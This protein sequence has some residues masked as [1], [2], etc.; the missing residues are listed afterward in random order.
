MRRQSAKE[1]LSSVAQSCPTFCDPADCSMPGLLVHHQLPEIAQTHVHRVSDAIQPSH[2]L[3]S[4][5]LPAFNPSKHQG[6]FWWVSSLHQVV[7]ELELQLQ[8]QSFC[9]I[10]RIDFLYGWLVLKLFASDWGLKLCAGTWT[11]PK[12]CLEIKHTWLRYKSSQN[13]WYLVS[14]Y[15]LKLRFL[16]SHCRKNSVRDKVIGKK[17]IYSDSEGSTL[18]RQSLSHFRGQVW[19]QNVAQLVFIS[20][21]ISY[22]NEWENYSNYFGEVVISKIWATA[23]FGLLTVPWNGHGTSGC[24]ILLAG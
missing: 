23:L 2:P 14:H 12:P 7:K 22:A 5:S 8:H 18:H 9:W 4:P 15:L 3:S 13:P 11:Q 21:V 19:L 6:L 24:I 16:M 10:L 20:W 17:W 1:N